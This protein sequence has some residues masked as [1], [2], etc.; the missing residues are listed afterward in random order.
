MANVID[1]AKLPSKTARQVTVRQ[2][3]YSGKGILTVELLMIF[4]IVAIRVVADYEVQSNGTVKG[5]VLSPSGQLGPLPILVT[6]VI[7]FF[8]LS[9][10]AAGGGTRAK[11]AG[12][13]GGIIV[14][15]LAMKSTAEIT[16]VSTTIGSIGT[17]TT[18]TQTG[19]TS[20]S[21]SPS[22]TSTPSS[23]GNPGTSSS[24][25]NSNTNTPL[26]NSTGAAER[27]LG[28]LVSSFPSDF[29]GSFDILSPSTIIKSTGN[30]WNAFQKLVG[31][32]GIS[33]GNTLTQGFNEIKNLF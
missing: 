28:S 31:D 26:E 13:L 20:V 5:N 16:K 21:S 12:I 24:S 33:V 8:I 19:S 4:A 10:V 22:S 18:P 9:F 30:E 14:V 23:S 2:T 25:S 1:T 7:T 32:V 15:G 3:S 11:L 27:A 29:T 17:I 6:S